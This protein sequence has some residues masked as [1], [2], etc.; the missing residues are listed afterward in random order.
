[1]QQLADVVAVL[2]VPVPAGPG[3]AVGPGAGPVADQAALH[4][5]QHLQRLRARQAQ[6]PLQELGVPGGETG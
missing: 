6:G 3:H 2:A 4:G 1:M 5:L